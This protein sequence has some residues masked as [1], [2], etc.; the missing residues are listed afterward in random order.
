VAKK[1]KTDVP[2]GLTPELKKAL[3]DF[4]KLVKEKE[5][6]FC[7]LFFIHTISILDI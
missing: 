5:R 4:P 2:L 3:R 7:F 1:K 6:N